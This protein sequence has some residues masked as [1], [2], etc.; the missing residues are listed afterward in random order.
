VRCVRQ[1]LEEEVMVPEEVMRLME[2]A[3]RL[4]LEEGVMA[5]EEEMRLMELVAWL[6][7]W[8]EMMNRHLL[9]SAERE[10][11]AEAQLPVIA[12]CGQF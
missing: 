7:P 2:S 6:M 1:K 8:E 11:T 3:V 5:P 10:H 4:V 12:E 9:V